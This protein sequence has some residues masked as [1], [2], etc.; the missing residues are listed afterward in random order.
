MNKK[1]DLTSGQIIAIV[2]AIVGFV[3][4]LA[5]LFSFLYTEG[6]ERDV[7][8]L[9]I[10]TRATTPE[11]A[12]AAVPLKCKAK[13]ICISESASKGCAK[14][15]SGE[16]DISY[17]KLSG[18]SEQKI[19]KIEEI[20]ANA[21]YDCWKMTGEGKLDIFGSAYHSLGLDVTKP[22]CIICSRIAVDEEISEDIINKVNINNYM[23]N[24]QVP[25]S[26]YTYL[27]TFTDAGISSYA[28]VPDDAL[29]NLKKFNEGLSISGE[30]SSNRELAIVFMQIKSQTISGVLN[31][32]GLAGATVAAG[33]FMTP[34]GKTIGRL[35]FTPTGAIVSVTAGAA[36]AGYGAYNAYQGQLAAAGYCG[37]FASNDEKAKEGC[38]LVQ[39]V[40]WN[41]NDVNNLCSGGLQGKI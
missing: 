10:L 32:L 26:K 38:S 14:Q 41:V 40:N 5:V 1:G 23:E 16:K 13:K 2:L 15:F 29:S 7:C 11:I 22:T 8:H 34:A 19:A 9:S 3:I 35:A 18:T 25:G 20:S 6:S 31:T 4:V 21:M 39:G 12:Q 27:Q 17:I 30:S 24:R 36:F 28:S 33:T 37:K